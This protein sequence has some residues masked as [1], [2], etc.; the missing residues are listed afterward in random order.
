[1]TQRQTYTVIET[2]KLLGIAR[3]S[4]YEAVQRGEIQALRFGKRIVV[5]RAVIRK[6]LGEE[7]DDSVLDEQNAA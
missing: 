6:M 5:P 3:N 1:M 2:S 7:P 4:A